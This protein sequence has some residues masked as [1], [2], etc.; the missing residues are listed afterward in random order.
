M[1]VNVWP[2]DNLERSASATTLL[3][4]S[5]RLLLSNAYTALL[6]VASPAALFTHVMTMVGPF[7]ATHC[8]LPGHTIVCTGCCCL[9]SQYIMALSKP[10]VTSKPVSAHQVNDLIGAEC[11]ATKVCVIAPPSS[12]HCTA[13]LSPPHVK[14]EAPSLCQSTHRAGRFA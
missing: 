12:L 14:R 6:H 9:R 1:G 4:L 2:F 7:D 5:L 13:A 10:P 3:M 11:F 8:T